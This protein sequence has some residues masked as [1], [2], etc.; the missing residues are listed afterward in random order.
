MAKNPEDRVLD[1]MVEGGI[2][3]MRLIRILRAEGWPVPE[4]LGEFYEWLD[5]RGFTVHEGMVTL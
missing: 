1:F 3:G 4:I 2:E 5:E